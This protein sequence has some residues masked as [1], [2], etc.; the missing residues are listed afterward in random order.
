MS[1]GSLT[2]IALLVTA[3][4]VFLGYWA[5]QNLERVE[6]EYRD[7]S[8]LEA[9][10]NPLLAS[11]MFLSRMQVETASVSGRETLLNRATR[12][13]LMSGPRKWT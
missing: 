5:F 3:L 6:E 4:F 13:W 12:A 1:R 10:K 7:Q 8:S 11:Q 2:V 9:R